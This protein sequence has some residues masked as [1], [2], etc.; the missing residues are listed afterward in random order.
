MPAE[1]EVQPSLLGGR[2]G[3]ERS[4]WEGRKSARWDEPE[5]LFILEP[6]SL[7]VR[8]G[9]QNQPGPPE[10]CLEHSVGK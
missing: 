5:L 6:V 1:C 8:K 4:R 3:A 9:K 7:A 10:Q 2:M